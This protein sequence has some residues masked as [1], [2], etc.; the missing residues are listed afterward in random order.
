MLIQIDGL[1]GHSWP[2]LADY[3]KVVSLHQ[4]VNLAL[5]LAPALAFAS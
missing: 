1:I 4:A 5:A 3:T 2:T